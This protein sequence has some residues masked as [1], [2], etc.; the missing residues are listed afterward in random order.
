[1]AL[2]A[3]CVVAAG[4][5]AATGDSRTWLPLKKADVQK[6]AIETLGAS[7]S[8]FKAMNAAA[9]QRTGLDA[10]DTIS[11]I[12]KKEV[13]LVIIVAGKGETIH[14]LHIYFPVVNN[15]E[16]QNQAGLKFL[17]A[18]FK[19][20]YPTW[21]G[22]EK[23]P[24]DSLRASWN[25]SPLITHRAPTDPDSLIIRKSLDGITSST[26]GVPPDLVVYS[27]TVRTACIPEATRGNPFQRLVC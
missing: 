4:A 5:R 15:S 2:F 11:V 6:I 1:M 7:A 17:S 16:A 27:V 13:P 23:W 26:V 12:Q 24:E 3:A 25:A 20:L 10:S 19:R 8:G 9:N 22:A 18:L 21:T 14:S